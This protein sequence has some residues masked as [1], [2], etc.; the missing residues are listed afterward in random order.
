MQIP[1]GKSFHISFSF[2]PYFLRQIAENYSTYPDPHI[3]GN[4]STST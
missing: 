2:H 1:Y 4:L 3:A